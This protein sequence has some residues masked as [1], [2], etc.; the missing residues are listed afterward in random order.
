MGAG[1]VCARS[2]RVGAGPGVVSLV[3]ESVG[4]TAVSA[5]GELHF[6]AVTHLWVPSTL[7]GLR[8]PPSWRIDVYVD[9]H[10]CRDTVET[11][12]FVS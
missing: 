6:D 10:F 4:V 5:P 7:S 8:P 1:L 11:S 9:P 12:W 3:P 2:L